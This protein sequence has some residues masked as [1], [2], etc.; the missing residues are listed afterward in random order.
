MGAA[1]VF[2]NSGIHVQLGDAEVVLDPHH[3]IASSIVSHAH[4]DHLCSGA[5][6][7]P[8]TLDIMKVRLRSSE[9]TGLGYGQAAEVGGMHVT[10]HD[11]GH[12][13]GSAMVR[14]EDVLYTGDLNPE[15][16]L[17]CGRAEPEGCGVLITEST[18]GRPDFNFPPKQE[19]MADL[20]SWIESC[21]EAGPVAIGAYEFGKAQELIA[22][23]NRLGHDAVVTDRIAELSDVY[24]L[25]GMGLRY[26][27]MRE[28]ED[29][30]LEAPHVMVVPRRLLRWGRVPEMDHFRRARGKAAFVSGWCARFNFRSSLNIDA[31][32]PLSDHAD[33]DSLL[34]FIGECK[35]QVV[36]TCNGYA[37]ELAREVRRRLR[38]EAR[39]LAH[40]WF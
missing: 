34:W 2:F 18:Y 10:L 32:F 8:Q 30:E 29:G 14:A 6:M 19:V 16:G 35:P 28:L 24:N 1:R 39:S 26:R 40:A 4:M 21:L 36:Y 9:G 22:L 13:F 23:A 27:R 11:A 33:F 25:H 5:H 38:V 3:P 37:E 15:G 7:T 17:T 31:Q 20:S 12:V